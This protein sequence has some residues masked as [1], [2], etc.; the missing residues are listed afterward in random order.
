MTVQTARRS[1]VDSQQRRDATYVANAIATGMAQSLRWPAAEDSSNNFDYAVVMVKFMADLLHSDRSSTAGLHLIFLKALD[2]QNGMERLVDLHHRYFEEAS[3][4]TE[5]PEAERDDS[6][7][8]RLIH[9]IGGLKV[10]LGVVQSLTSH[11]RLLPPGH[12]LMLTQDKQSSSYFDP[13][14]FLVK[15]R[16]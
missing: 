4:L 7:K 15:L 8:L 13:H 2:K 1:N 5:I 14:N 6:A 9:A 16:S 12:L 3:R 10:V 11:K